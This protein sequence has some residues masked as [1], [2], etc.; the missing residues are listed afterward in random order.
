MVGGLAGLRVCGL[1][2]RLSRAVVGVWVFLAPA[3]CGHGGC[4]SVGREVCAA[5]CAV[6][7]AHAKTGT[8]EA[9]QAGPRVVAPDR[10]HVTPARRM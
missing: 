7:P 5:E 3:R 8:A 9:S 4:L 2:G 1:A 10:A 6:T